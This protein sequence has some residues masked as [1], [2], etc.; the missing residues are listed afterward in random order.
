MKFYQVMNG[1]A[2]HSMWLLILNHSKSPFWHLQRRN[3]SVSPFSLPISTSLEH[4]SE[5]FSVSQRKVMD[6]F[7]GVFV[8]GSC[9]EVLWPILF[10]SE[11]TVTFL[12][13]I[14]TSVNVFYLGFN[15]NV[16]CCGIHETFP[17]DL[18]PAMRRSCLVSFL[19]RASVNTFSVAF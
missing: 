4:F 2:S 3:F 10:R 8:T 11:W 6:F 5:I 15:A 12:C 17:F 1:R 14:L 7:Y 16:C 18:V 9:G 13:L 19:F